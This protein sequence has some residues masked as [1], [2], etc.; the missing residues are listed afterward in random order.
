M[1]PSGCRV[2]T[3]GKEI[4]PLFL[5]F[6]L[7]WILSYRN[8]FSVPGDDGL[9]A[10]APVQADVGAL[11]GR[12]RA[13]GAGLVTVRG[14]AVALIRRHTITAG[15]VKPYNSIKRDATR[16]LFPIKMQNHSTKRQTKCSPSGSSVS[17]DYLGERTSEVGLGAAGF[18]AGAAERS[19]GAGVTVLR[20]RAASSKTPHLT[21]CPVHHLYEL[22]HPGETPQ[23]DYNNYIVN[24]ERRRQRNTH[25]YCHRELKWFGKSLLQLKLL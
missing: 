1:T 15:A 14:G 16:N 18:V 4:L 17:S 23:W 9:L 10:A 11:E 22:S 21:V 6:N 7:P 8:Q 24:H 25:C 20:L 3:H 2:F 12:A 19:R 13:G 5:T